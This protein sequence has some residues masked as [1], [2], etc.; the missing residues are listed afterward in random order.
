M[1]LSELCSSCSVLSDRPHL[2]MIYLYFGAVSNRLLDELNLT[3]LEWE[4][5][6]AFCLLMVAKE[7]MA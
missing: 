7:K 1:T 4:E 6:E 3:P 2:A 5:L